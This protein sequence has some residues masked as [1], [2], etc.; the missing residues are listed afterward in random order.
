MNQA[1][2]DWVSIAYGSLLGQQRG[3]LSQAVQPGM[4]LNACAL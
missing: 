1:D 2:E 4:C 3:V